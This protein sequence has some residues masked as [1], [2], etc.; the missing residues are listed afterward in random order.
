MESV[1]SA[2]KRDGD[3]NSFSI[4]LD[5]TTRCTLECPHCRR[6]LYKLNNQKVPGRDMTMAEYEK[7]I[8]FYPHVI[9][10]GNASDPI[11]HPQFIDFLALNYQRGIDTVID[12][13][14]TGKSLDWYRK[15]FAAN[16]DAIWQ[17]GL[18]GFPETSDTYRK[19]QDGLKLFEAMK[20][21]AEMGLESIWR[22]I[23]FR[24]NE[25]DRDECQK[26][27]DYY[28]IK[29]QF[30]KSSRFGENDP[31]KPT[32]DFIERKDYDEFATEMLE[33]AART[34]PRG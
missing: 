14:A 18:D 9:F 34:R 28:S 26:I 6:Q 23:I 20:L 3:M 17:F 30:V 7:V 10:C 1:G 32:K 19:N 4:N 2:V 12:H 27:A 29:L 22:Y 15:A 33:R 11:F 21:C 5:I 8:V 31:L 25:D 13:A 16:P 24:Y